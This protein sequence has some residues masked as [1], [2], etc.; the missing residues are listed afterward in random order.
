MRL[1][2]R[3]EPVSTDG[4]ELDERQAEAPCPEPVAAPRGTTGARGV[5]GRPVRLL[6]TDETLQ[7]LAER[8]AR[9]RCPRAQEEVIRRCWGW[10]GRLARGV[11]R[12]SGLEREIT[13]AV[14]GLALCKALARYDPDRGEFEPFARA[15]TAGEVRHFLRVAVWPVHVPRRLQED[16]YLVALLRDELAGRLGR[17]PDAELVSRATNLTE[18]QVRAVSR[19]SRRVVSLDAGGAPPVFSEAQTDAVADHVDLVRAVQALGP[20]ERRLLELRFYEG[21]AQREIGVMLETNQV[22]VSRMLT[23]VLLKLRRVME[24]QA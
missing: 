3:T 15:V 20:A 18:V 23:A 10:A 14:A 6:A 4:I 7:E 12:H 13:D 17:E 1:A 8:F 16:Y 9:T 5:R 22:K 24:D 21:F 11:A 19:L 2:E